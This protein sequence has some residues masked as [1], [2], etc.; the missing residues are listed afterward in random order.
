MYVI[1]NNNTECSNGSPW[2]KQ[3]YFIVVLSSGRRDSMSRSAS[4]PHVAPFYIFYITVPGAQQMR[5]ALCQNLPFGFFCPEIKLPCRVICP[6][7]NELSQQTGQVLN[8]P[9]TSGE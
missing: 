3:A 2:T 1:S 5:M 7:M 6:N 9:Y 8:C 4:I